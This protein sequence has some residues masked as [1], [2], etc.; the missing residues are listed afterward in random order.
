MKTLEFN[1]KRYEVDQQ[2]FLTDPGKW[3]PD[4]AEGVAREIGMAVPLTDQQWEVIHFIRDRFK[5]TGTCPVVFETTRAL[6]LDPK[7][8]QKLFPTGYFRGACLLSGISYKYGWVYY[9]GEPYPVAQKSEAEQKQKTPPENKVYR[10]DLFG[11]L[12]D[13]SEWDEDF[14]MRRAF[15]MN[16]KGGLS[17][18]H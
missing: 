3:D 6:K 2:N 5:A 16:M 10:V 13:F 9:F 11:A 14:A 18:R 17:E 7:T 4:F 12:V 15:E 8:L 1:Q